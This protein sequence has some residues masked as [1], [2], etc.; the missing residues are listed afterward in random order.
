[1][2]ID[3]VHSLNFSRLAGELTGVT[4]FATALVFS[5]SD[6]GFPPPQSIVISPGTNTLERLGFV[7]AYASGNLHP[8]FSRTHARLRTLSIAC[9][10]SSWLLT[11]N[12]QESGT[13]LSICP[14]L[15]LWL[16]DCDFTSM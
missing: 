5:G 8:I 14:F 10:L 7:D 3:E 16:D 13:G 6:A 9:Y 12:V 4:M 11:F 15:R 2:P 1:M